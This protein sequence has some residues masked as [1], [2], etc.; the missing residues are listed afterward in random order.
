MRWRRAG[1][2]R[3]SGRGSRCPPAGYPFKVFNLYPSC[4]QKR[5]LLFG[6]YMNER[7]LLRLPHRQILSDSHDCPGFT[8]PRAQKHLAPVFVLPPAPLPIGRSEIGGGPD[9]TACV[10]PLE[11]HA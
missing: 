11:H 10:Y 6:E 2:G 7:L 4:S 9:R 1:S 8:W 5:T 3:R